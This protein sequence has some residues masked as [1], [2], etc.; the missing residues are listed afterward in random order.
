MKLAPYSYTILQYRHDVWTGE[1]LNL[2]VLLY[3]PEQNYLALRA[4]KGRGRLAQAYPNLDHAA[5][6]ETIKGLQKFFAQCLDKYGFLSKPD[7]ALEF[8]R[9]VLA[10]DD[11]SLRWYNNG[12]G[13]TPAHDSIFERMVSRYDHEEGRDPITDEMVFDKVKGRLQKAELLH[14]MQPK[15]V[16]SDFATVSFSHTIQ[17]GKLHCVQPVSFDSAN[18]DQMQVKATNWAGRMLGLQGKTDI[19]PYFITGK[20]TDKSFMAKYTQMQN[21]LRISPLAPIVVDAEEVDSVVCTLVEA[22]RGQI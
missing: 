3:C 13:L 11:S 17:N 15:I 5:L 16:S 21:L 7:T 18:E 9:S 8:G 2:G 1:A 4:R 12:N 14:L 19:R 10:E 6:R 20:P 22:V